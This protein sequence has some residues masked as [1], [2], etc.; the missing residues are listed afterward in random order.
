M[1][2]FKMPIFVTS[3]ILMMGFSA[4]AVSPTPKQAPQEKLILICQSHP[5]G[6][7]AVSATVVE[8]TDEF[9]RVSY[10]L[11][12]RAGSKGEIYRGKVVIHRDVA[13]YFMEETRGHSVLGVSTLKK[14]DLDGYRGFLTVPGHVGVLSCH[15]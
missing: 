12:A 4:F 8:H 1:F 13:G 15:E 6:V 3:F 10:V 5:S 7:V 2:R 14:D 11:S 9:G